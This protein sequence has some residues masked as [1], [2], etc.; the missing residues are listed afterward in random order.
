MSINGLNAQKLGHYVLT[1]LGL[2]F[3]FDSGNWIADEKLIPIAVIFAILI[4]SIFTFGIGTSIYLMIPIMC[5][6]TGSIRALP[7]PS[8]NRHLF[9]FVAGCVFISYSTFKSQLGVNKR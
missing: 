8:S 7:L 3:A 4:S 1:P 9:I 5:G 6:M 2:F